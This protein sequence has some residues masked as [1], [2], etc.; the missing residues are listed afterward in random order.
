MRVAIHGHGVGS[1]DAVYAF[2]VLRLATPRERAAVLELVPALAELVPDV[3]EVTDEI[4][5]WAEDTGPIQLVALPWQ[6]PESS[7][8]AGAQRHIVEGLA[9]VEAAWFFQTDG[10]EQR[11]TV[12]TTVDGYPAIL[13]TIDANDLGVA[14]KLRGVALPGESMVL[15]H[16]L[17]LW[18]APYEDDLGATAVAFDRTHNAAHF[19]VEQFGADIG[20]DELV[21]RTLWLVGELGAVLPVLHAR[22]APATRSQKAALHAA[23]VFVL[24]GNPLLA[25]YDRGG[26]TEVDAWLATQETWS[27]VEAAAMLRELAVELVTTPAEEP[28]DH[29]HAGDPD[30]DLDDL[31]EDLDDDD[32][33]DAGLSSGAGFGDEDDEEAGFQITSYAGDLLRERAAA[34]LLDPRAAERLLPVLGVPERYEHRRQA[35]VDVFGALRYRPAVPGMIEILQTTTIKNSLDSIGK[36]DFIASAAAALGAIGDPAAVPALAKVVAAPGTHNDTPRP[37]AAAALA[38]CLAATPEPR[39]VDEEVLDELLTTICERNDGE[40]NAETHFAYGKLVRLLPPE[41]RAEARRKLADAD[42][43]RDDA[44]AMLARQAALL[45]ASP[46]TPIDVPPRDLQ[47]LL[48]E[49]LT[50]LDYDHEYTVRNLRV[51]LR[52]AEIVPDLVEPEDLI[53]LTRFAEPDIRRLAHALLARLGRPHEPA[54]AFDRTS[55]RT[56]ADEDIVRLIAEPHV[57]GRGALIAEA[58]RR[59]LASARRAV[60]DACHDV[61]SRA[62]Q[63][64]EN[65]LDPDTRV[66]EAALPF[67]REPPLDADA[68]ALFDRMLRHSNVHVKWELVEDAPRDERL[69]G[70]M[71]H[72]L[73]EK[74]GW[75]ENAAKAWLSHFR[76]TQAYEAER[77]RARTT[78]SEPDVPRAAQQLDVDDE[79]TN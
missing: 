2:F 39:H 19:W 62:R 46:T 27:A 63:G 8:A 53:W 47:P 18:L 35:V 78:T 73:G 7:D 49:S 11:E 30:D 38:A 17:A 21:H 76:G 36:E 6:P 1:G 33:D 54:P 29:D 37:V 70:G 64:G 52:V 24:G 71:F 13:D 68:I 42:T 66:L 14:V 77:R 50:T 23:D 4:E 15:D 3:D 57:V 34:G 65:L 61:I 9:G 60:I 5:G 40:L 55:V 51:A 72:V 31:D 10:T 44:I 43:A 20:A 25:I 26:E 45:L 75:Q 59:R 56:L 74:W 22:F 58:G 12:A 79:D 41:R 32:D 48:R 16:F 67:L 28:E 69:I